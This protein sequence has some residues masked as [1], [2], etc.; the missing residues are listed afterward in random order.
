MLELGL[1]TLEL[2]LG[3]FEIGLYRTHLLSSFVLT[4]LSTLEPVGSTPLPLGLA[5]QQFES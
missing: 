4:H 5:F 3:T 1:D 2:G